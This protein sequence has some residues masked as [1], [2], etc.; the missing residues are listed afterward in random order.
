M[1]KVLSGAIPESAQN[2][3]GQCERSSNRLGYFVAEGY[4][5]RKLRAAV[6]LAAGS[7]G[8][9]VGVIA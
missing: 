6:K 5:G 7:V 4:E 2:N 8:L 1:S 3:S 9:L